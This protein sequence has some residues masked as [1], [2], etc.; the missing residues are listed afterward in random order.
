MRLDIQF[1]LGRNSGVKS[2]RVQGLPYSGLLAPV[3]LG[4]WKVWKPAM[5]TPED[6]VLDSYVQAQLSAMEAGGSTFVSKL[7]AGSDLVVLLRGLRP[8]L[9]RL[10][11]SIYIRL[12]W[13][14]GL[15]VVGCN[16]PCLL[17]GM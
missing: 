3:L 8:L 15:F 5:C 9:A 10:G 7:L 16:L 11:T 6:A 12:T 17:F 2:C 4:T 14:P 1:A 13:C